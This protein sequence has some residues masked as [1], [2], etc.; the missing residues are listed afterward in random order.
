MKRLTGLDIME[1]VK[2]GLLEHGHG[3]IKLANS[4]ANS[5]TFD[6]SPRTLQDN[7]LLYLCMHHYYNCRNLIVIN[8]YLLNT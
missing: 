3:I 2:A 6:G 8:T 5:I 1:A 7:P 4:P